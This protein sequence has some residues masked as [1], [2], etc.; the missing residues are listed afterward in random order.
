MDQPLIE[1]QGVI[2]GETYRTHS[3]SNG[4]V[5][6]DPMGENKKVE[7][8][9]RLNSLASQDFAD[10]GA[11][12]RTRSLATREGTDQLRLVEQSK[13]LCVNPIKLSWNNVKFEVEVR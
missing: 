5:V 1:G 9:E 3:L 8:I 4:Q 2:N 11:A 7:A 13:R 10:P 12:K 6:I